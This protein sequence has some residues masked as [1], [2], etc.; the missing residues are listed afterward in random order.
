MK[1]WDFQADARRSTKG[2]LLAFLLLV[3]TIMVSVHLALALVFW[4]PALLVVATTTLTFGE[5][6][7]TY[8]VGFLASNV[9]LVSLM[10][11]GGAWVK[12]DNLKQGGVHLARQLGARELRP[13]VSHT[14]QR[15]HNIVAE[16]CVAAGA[17]VPQ[18]M[19]MPR[20]MSLNAF[21]AAWE[22]KD[23]VIVVSQ[24]ALEYLSRDE[25]TGVLA[26]ELAHLHEG[27]TRL[28]MELAG[29]VFGLEMLFNY[30]RDLVEHKMSILGLP[31]KGV[32][33]LGW[34]AGQVLKAAVSRQRE[35]LADARAVQWTR[36]VDGLGR[37]LRKALWQQ[38]YPSQAFAAAAWGSARGMQSP[39]VE[40]ML[41]VDSADSACLHDGWHLGGGDW[42]AS[43]PALEERIAR[44]YGGARDAVPLQDPDKRWSNP[45]AAPLP[46]AKSDGSS[47]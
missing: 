39:L 40:H 37:A 23:A 21:A 4:V 31:L 5:V 42:L 15:C 12:R 3:L 9:G 22:S 30:G 46:L 32:G 24:G 36:N 18:L 29:Y 35:Y 20:D 38:D 13:S 10:V 1:F 25:L 45:F 41:L 11:L 17:Q 28:N 6:S 2:L 47:I 19:V 8:P 34:L 14:D 33:W 43:H 7:V 26:H 27:D 44:I 16:L